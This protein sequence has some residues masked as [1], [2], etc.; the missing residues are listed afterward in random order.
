M[1]GTQ[2]QGGTGAMPFGKSKAKVINS[3]S[4]TKVTF[5]DEIGRAHV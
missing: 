1:G 2:R 5:N 4:K 3:N